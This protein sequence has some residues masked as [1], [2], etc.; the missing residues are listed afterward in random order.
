MANEKDTVTNEDLAKSIDSLLT[1]LGTEAPASED[2]EKA[3][4]EEEKIEKSMNHLGTL[5]G[6]ADRVGAPPLDPTLEMGGEEQEDLLSEEEMEKALDALL[7]DENLAKSLDEVNEEEGAEDEVLD[8][9]AVET[10]FAKSLAESFA[11]H[12]VL[13]EIAA[14]NDFA[15]SLVIGT[16]E[17]LALQQEELEKSLAGMEERSDKKFE[18]LAKAVANIGKA[19]LEIKEAVTSM[20]NSPVRPMAKSVRT[21]GLEKSFGSDAPANRADL[22][23]SILSALEIRVREGKIDPLHFVKYD[24]TGVIDPALEAEVMK[25]L[26]LA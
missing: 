14:Q 6:L 7:S 26:K 9:D 16:I 20:G 24:A 23:K 10:E 18:V 15:K 22:K 3:V 4:E 17:G 25:E 21:T 11:Q 5:G 13:A 2:V 1:V 19:V 12:E 8:A